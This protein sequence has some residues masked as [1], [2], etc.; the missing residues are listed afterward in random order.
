M[1]ENDIYAQASFFETQRYGP[2]YI[3]SGSHARGR[4][5]HAFLLDPGQ[6]LTPNP[7][8]GTNNRHPSLR[9]DQEIYGVV[10]GQ[11]GWT[12]EYGWIQDHPHVQD[13]SASKLF[14]QLIE[15]N[16]QARN[17]LG[18]RY[19][20]GRVEWLATWATQNLGI[21]QIEVSLPDLDG[22]SDVSKI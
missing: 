13:G 21:A 6:E 19:Q 15:A 9:D 18:M 11:R 17:L 4:T 7:R 10:Q 3:V 12:E 8:S 20:L 16:E 14:I 5:L 2:L 1:T 22:L